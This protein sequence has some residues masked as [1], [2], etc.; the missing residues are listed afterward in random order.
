MKKYLLILLVF[1]IVGCSAGGSDNGDGAGGD[2]GNGGGNDGG[3]GNGGGGNGGGGNDGGGGNGGGGGIA[4]PRYSWQLVGNKEFSAGKAVDISLAIDG[5]GIPYVAYS[6]SDN[7]AKVMKLDGNTWSQVGKTVSSDN[8]I[9]E[10]T[11][12]AIYNNTPYVAYRFG[13]SVSDGSGSQVNAQAAVRSWNGSGWVYV[14]DETV[15]TDQAVEFT[16]LAFDN[17]GIPYLAYVFGAD[18][19]AKVMKLVGNAWVKADF[20]DSAGNKASHTSLVVNNNTIYAAYLQPSFGEK[21][22]TV[23]KKIG[24]GW[25]AIPHPTGEGSIG[26]GELSGISLAFD[27]NGIPYVAYIEQAGINDKVMVE[28]YISSWA[29]VVAGGIAIPAVTAVRDISLAFDNSGIPYVAYIQVDKAKVFKLVGN[30]WLDTGIVSA[31]VV[32]ADGVSKKMS[33]AIYN[34]IPYVAFSDGTGGKTTV[35]KYDVIK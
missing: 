34:N 4:D 20:S 25:Q 31:G 29:D 8:V 7:K 27:K 32:A 3:G 2:N 19:K 13:R 35:M 17:A 26:G 10:Y 18:N 23:M 6:D 16:S 22:G 11:S 15:S 5:N 21:K 24:S 30:A 33:M 12:L 14:G 9:A 1:A 28:K